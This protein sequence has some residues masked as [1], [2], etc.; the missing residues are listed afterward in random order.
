MVCCCAD[1]EGNRV[2]EEAEA[3][4]H[5]ASC[6]DAD[7]SKDAVTRKGITTLDNA[8]MMGL[9]ERIRL[10]FALTPQ[11]NLQC[12][13]CSNEGLG[14]DTRRYSPANEE[15]V[16]AL[17]EMLLEN[18]GLRSID[19]SGGEP[20]LHPDI[21]KGTNILIEWTRTHP[22]IRF[23]FHTNGV[24][25]APGLVDEIGSHFARIGVSIHSV[26]YATWNSMTNSGRIA[27]KTQRRNWAT[28]QTNL[29]YL[30][31]KGIGD[32][33]F[34]KA[35][36]VRGYNDS[37]T[38][39][40]SFLDASAEYG[41]HPK[42]LQFEPQCDRQMDLQVGRK[43]LFDKLERVGCKF[44]VDA[45]RHNDPNTYIPA[46]LFTHEDRKSAKRGMHVILECGTPAACGSCYAFLCFFTKP[47]EDGQGL[48]LKPCSVHD[49][50]FDLTAAIRTGNVD[51]LIDTFKA[52]REYLMTRP[53]LGVSNWGREVF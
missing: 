26:N 22:E 43:E 35:V 31:E 29:E 33:V 10:R 8:Q 1:E 12:F 3:T 2:T 45:P 23:S 39:L 42:F 44:P 32:K 16:I 24:L 36:V 40:K 41:F 11:C 17:S 25:L 49:T 13:F 15:L 48:Y 52:S 7:I 14:Y 9:F 6:G 4:V 53:G 47:T 34:L 20:T 28:L 5:L 21:A 50:R 19:F 37:E 46:T 18:T 51:R 30:A 27:E 38:E